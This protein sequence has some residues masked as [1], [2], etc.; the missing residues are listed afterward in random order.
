[1]KNGVILGLLLIALV[2]TLILFCVIFFQPQLVPKEGRW[3]CDELQLQLGFGE[4]SSII[5]SE[6]VRA[7]CVTVSLNGDSNIVVHCQ[8]RNHPEWRFDE[9]V[10][11][12]ECIKLEEN[13]LLIREQH[14]DSVYTFIRKGK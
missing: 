6:G 14:T 4:E 2:C 8:D 10:F 12:G 1:M 11:E 9:V 13:T 7:S 5:S 3:Y